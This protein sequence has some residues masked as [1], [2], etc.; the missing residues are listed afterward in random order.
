MTN[1]EQFFL[2]PICSVKVLVEGN[3]KQRHGGSVPAGQRIGAGGV[4]CDGDGIR[5]VEPSG[6]GDE[7]RGHEQLRVLPGWAALQQDGERRAAAPGVGR[8]EPGL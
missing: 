4:R 7:R 1:R 6:E 3:I 2:F 8:H 5:R